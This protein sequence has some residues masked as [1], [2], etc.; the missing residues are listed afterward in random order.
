MVADPE[1]VFKVVVP[2]L[3]GKGMM[4]TSASARARLVQPPLFAV[5]AKNEVFAVKAADVN[6]VPVATAVPPV[7]VVYQL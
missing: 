2:G 4:V 6:V 3:L 7:A 1:Q 5:S